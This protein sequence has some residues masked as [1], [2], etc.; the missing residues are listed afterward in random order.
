LEV[1]L[2]K[3]ILTFAAFLFVV[4]ITQ[5]HSFGIGVQA[6]G[7]W[8][9]SAI[10]YGASL[11]ISPYERLHFAV[12]YYLNESY[13]MVGGSADYWFFTASLFDP[14]YFYVGGGIGTW[15][16]LGNTMTVYITPRLP[17]GLDFVLGYFDIYLQLVPQFGIG[18]LPGFSVGSVRFGGNIG[19]RFWFDE[20]NGYY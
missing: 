16:G 3:K 15:I 12:D 18:L 13:T 9:N 6:N 5:G 4:G 1:I 20:H 2:N 7:S 8:Y 11:L 17:L 19:I 10:G 14:C